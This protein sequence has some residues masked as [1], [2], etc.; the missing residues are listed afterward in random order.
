MLVDNKPVEVLAFLPAQAEEVRKEDSL[1]KSIQYVA[2]SILSAAVYAAVWVGIYYRINNQSE[3]SPLDHNDK[4]NDPSESSRLNL[5]VE[6]SWCRDECVREEEAITDLLDKERDECNKA[7]HNA[8][9]TDG[10][11]EVIENCIKKNDLVIIQ[12]PK[13]F[14]KTEKCFADCQEDYDRVASLKI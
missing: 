10:E 3:S 2:L 8:Y 4:L 1:N 6:L 12:K 5:D 14:A 7:I 13:I 9:G 11:W